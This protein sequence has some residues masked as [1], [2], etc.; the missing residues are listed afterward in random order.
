MFKQNKYSQ[1]YYSIINR[2]KSR[3]I[4]GYYEKHH[5]I[6]RSLG[7]ADDE[8]NLVK[9]TAREH[10]ICH[11]L[12]PK[13]L[14]GESYHKMLYA[15]VI[16]SGR[17]I[18]GSRKYAFYREEYSKIASKTGAL[19]PMWGVDRSGEKKYI[20]RYETHRRN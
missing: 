19:N 14:E 6:P 18:Y 11:L 7:G 10:F 3:D 12:L 13:M 9:L 5:V 17:K 1:V 2:A 16:M 15:Y 8:T 4:S 20:L